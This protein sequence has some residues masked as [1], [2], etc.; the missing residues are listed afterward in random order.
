[1]DYG[2][3]TYRPAQGLRDFTAARDRTCRFPGCAQP[4]RRCDFDHQRPWPEGR[5]S[6]D[7]GE[8]LCEHH[9]RLKHRGGWRVTGNP[10]DVL[11]WTSPTGHLYYSPPHDYG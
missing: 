6:A 3:Q 11:T 8:Y 7:N 2:Q 4:A 1:M 9:H 5:T 10:N